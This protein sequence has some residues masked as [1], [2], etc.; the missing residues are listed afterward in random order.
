MDDAH[1][2]IIQFFQSLSS[3]P[4]SC[5]SSITSDAG[6]LGEV[7][8]DEDEKVNNWIDCILYQVS[9]IDLLILLIPLI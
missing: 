3:S 7:E 4:S 6:H 9:F 2:M 5:S 8:E 1:M